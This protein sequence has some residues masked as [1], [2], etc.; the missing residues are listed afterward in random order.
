MTPISIVL[1]VGA[2]LLHARVR[3][4]LTADSGMALVHDALDGADAARQIAYLTPSIV[5]CDR[6]MLNDPD[7]AVIR[8]R[9]GRCPHVVLITV[10]S[11]APRTTTSLTLAGTVPFDARADDMASRLRAI[12]L[13]EVAAASPDPSARRPVPSPMLVRLS[14]RFS[15]P[16]AYPTFTE[17]V[18]LAPLPLAATS[19]PMPRPTYQPVPTKTAQLKRTSFLKSMLDDSDPVLGREK[20]SLVS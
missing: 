14:E 19:A 3:S 10:N 6:Q 4:V 15:G 1:A 9:K 2:P 12:L 18:S 8:L 5:L 11:D 17:P 20:G 16:Q 7:F 13:A